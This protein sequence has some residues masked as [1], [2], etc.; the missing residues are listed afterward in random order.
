[1]KH[2]N[3]TPLEG[4]VVTDKGELFYLLQIKKISDLVKLRKDL[5]T[6]IDLISK[7]GN[8]GE[9]VNAINTLNGLLSGLMM[10]DNDHYEAMDIAL[11]DVFKMKNK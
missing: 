9:N 5:I 2:L 3:S 4:I 8:S 6:A 1:M 10:Y 7:C 11:A